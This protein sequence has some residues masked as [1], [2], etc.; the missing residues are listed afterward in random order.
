M[1]YTGKQPIE[2]AVGLFALAV[3]AWLG[4]AAGKAVIKA[5]ASAFTL[6][7]KGKIKDKKNLSSFFQILSKKNWEDKKASPEE[8]EKIVNELFT[9]TKSSRRSELDTEF[10]MNLA[11]A[12]L[13]MGIRSGRIKTYRELYHALKNPKWH[14]VVGMKNTTI[15][16]VRALYNGAKKTG[17]QGGKVLKKVEKVLK[18]K[19]NKPAEE[20]PSDEGKDNGPNDGELNKEE[21]SVLQNIEG[22]ENVESKDASPPEE[23]FTDTDDENE[24]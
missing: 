16:I 4:I 17:E 5:A 22:F 12:N 14:K 21:M 3:I 1:S 18:S 7:G 11:Q 24:K 9:V 6:F 20:D 13:I 8:L 23:E 10:L 2:E 19:K 15:D